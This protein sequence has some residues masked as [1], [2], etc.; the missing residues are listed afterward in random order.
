MSRILSS[1]F[2]KSYGFNSVVGQAVINS[3]YYV[4]EQRD[5]SITIPPYSIVILK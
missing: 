1:R 2:D 4:G 5:G 3:D